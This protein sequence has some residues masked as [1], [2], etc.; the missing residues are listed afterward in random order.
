MST[1]SRTG[2]FAV[3]FAVAFAE[4][5]PTKS[6]QQDHQAMIQTQTKHIC[7]KEKR[8]KVTSHKSKCSTS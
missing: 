7:N 6:I 5:Q 1:C 2:A 8:E 3:A 4:A